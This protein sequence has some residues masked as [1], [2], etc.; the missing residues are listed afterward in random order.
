VVVNDLDIS[1]DAPRPP[2]ADSVLVV[3]PDAVLTLSVTLE[4]L[5]AIPWRYPKIF[6]SAGNL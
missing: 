4:L 2:E 6:Q 1:R 5:E 3:D